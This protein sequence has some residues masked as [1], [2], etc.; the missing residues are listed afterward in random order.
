MKSKCAK[1]T[2]AD[3]V[4]YVLGKTV[5]KLALFTETTK[6]QLEAL[7]YLLISRNIEQ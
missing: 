3:M 5:I 7:Q 1:L 6:S 2:T 4:N